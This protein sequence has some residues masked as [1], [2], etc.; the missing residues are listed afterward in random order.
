MSCNYFLKLVMPF[1][2]A[3]DDFRMKIYKNYIIELILWPLNFPHSI[4]YL[5]S[6][7]SL[8]SSEHHI[9]F[10]KPHL[11]KNESAI[12]KWEVVTLKVKFESNVEL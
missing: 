10:I 3:Y 8:P 6:S 11:N 1:D 5:F 9:T 2:F 4:S 12:K 7:I